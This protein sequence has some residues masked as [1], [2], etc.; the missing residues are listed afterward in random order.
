[1]YKGI[2]QRS[3]EIDM[4]LTGQVRKPERSRRM[5]GIAGGPR[6]HVELQAWSRWRTPPS[7][8]PDLTIRAGSIGAPRWSIFRLMVNRNLVIL[9]H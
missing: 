5:F 9:N 3:K 7:P 2:G 8:N 6:Q 1:M 4:V